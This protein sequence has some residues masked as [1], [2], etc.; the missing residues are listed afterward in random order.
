MFNLTKEQ[1]EQMNQWYKEHVPEC[2]FFVRPPSGEFPVEVY[3]GAIGGALT[4]KFTPTTLGLT[5]VV[6]C[7]CGE[8]INLTDFGEW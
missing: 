1:A 4:Y 8:E 3:V 2:P 5:T 6:E 7:V